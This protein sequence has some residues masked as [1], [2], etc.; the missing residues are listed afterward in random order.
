MVKTFDN[1]SKK[2]Y[3]KDMDARSIHYAPGDGNGI[4]E[5]VMVSWGR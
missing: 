1:F 2:L 3:P 5:T 4:L